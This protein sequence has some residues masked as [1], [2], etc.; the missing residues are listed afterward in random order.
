M[1]TQKLQDGHRPGDCDLRASG[2]STDR[3]RRALIL[4]VMNY[5]S[6]TIHIKVSKRKT[7]MG[8]K[9]R[10]NQAQPS[11]CLLSGELHEDV[12]NSPQKL[13]NNTWHVLPTREAYPSLVQSFYWGVHSCTAHVTDL[14][15]SAC[16]SQ[17]P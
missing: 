2:G 14:S 12:L 13:C 3:T 8:V 5:L 15:Y 9:S 7:C 1:N 17:P 6:T 10:G 4:T 11:R 16:S